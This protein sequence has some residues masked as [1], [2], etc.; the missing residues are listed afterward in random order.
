MPTDGKQGDRITHQNKLLEI[1]FVFWWGGGIIEGLTHS[2]KT[3]NGSSAL[4]SKVT[5]SA[6][7]VRY[8]YVRRFGTQKSA[9]NS[10]DCHLGLLAG[11]T[12][13]LSRGAWTGT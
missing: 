7:Q 12:F 9:L 10:H 5:R 13:P 1:E 4:Q 6:D 2:P 11:E 3:N 8:N